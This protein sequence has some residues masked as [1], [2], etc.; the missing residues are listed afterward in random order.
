[1][2]DDLRVKGFVMAIEANDRFHRRLAEEEARDSQNTTIGI[3]VV[4]FFLGAVMGW[5]I[6][7]LL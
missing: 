6:A 4:A 1:M 2:D 7:C 5:V 3:A